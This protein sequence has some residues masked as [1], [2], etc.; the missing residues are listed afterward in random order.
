M[1]IESP[2]FLA[3]TAIHMMDFY[4][5]RIRSRCTDLNWN[6]RF[7]FREFFLTNCFCLSLHFVF[8]LTNCFCLALR[9]CKFPYELFAF[10]QCIGATTLDEHRKHIEKDKALARRFQPVMVNEPSQVSGRMV[11]TSV[12]FC[13]CWEPQDSCEGCFFLV[14]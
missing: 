14:C 10:L 12:V 13:G 5:G 9:F 4:S 1:R 11:P 8:F 7:H 6:W 3:K 2:D